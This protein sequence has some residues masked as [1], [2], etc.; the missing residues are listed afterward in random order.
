MARVRVTA[1]PDLDAPTLVEGLPG[2]GL[3][4]KITTD[5]LIGTF[6]ME[7]VASIEC[8]GVPP[9][10]IYDEDSR[11]VLPPVR[12]Y[13][14]ESRDLLALQSDVPISRQATADFSDCFTEW[15]ASRDATPLYLSGLPIEDHDPSTL[16]DVFGIATTD[17][18]ASRLQ[19]HGIETPP[20][21]GLIG[22]PTGA[23]IN[24]ASESSV[25][26]AG[27][28]VESDPQFPDPAAAKRLIEVTIEPL[29][30]VDVPTDDLVDRAEEIREQKQQ[31]AKAMQEAGDEE[32]TQ[33][34]PMRMFQ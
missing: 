24:A 34:R 6:D 2:V 26:A 15:L 10:T 9:V 5:H 28:V 20:E 25:D 21:R 30:D 27:L 23:L 11:D 16:P 33:A 31:L 3:V 22:G 13:A 1:E 7:Y 14:D 12:V 18:T 32:A 19:D 8:D 29:A 17:A 4:G